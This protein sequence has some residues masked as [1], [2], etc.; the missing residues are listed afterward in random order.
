MGYPDV[1]WDKRIRFICT[2]CGYGMTGDD[3]RKVTRKM[4]VMHDTEMDFFT[5][6]TC[7]KEAIVLW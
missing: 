2:D 6:P 7:G 5:C 1:Y 3:H 4:S